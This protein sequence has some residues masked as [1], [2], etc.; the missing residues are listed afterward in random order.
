MAKLPEKAARKAGSLPEDEAS[1]EL[2]QEISRRISS[3]I[4]QGQRAQVVAQVVSVVSEERFS[5]PIAHP[6]HLREYEE[7]CPGAADR[8]IR[9][10]EQNL[11]HN[12]SMQKAWI[13]GEIAEAK[14][15]RQYGFGA[16]LALILAASYAAAHDHETIAGL[17]LGAGIL[18]V[19]G[20][21]IQGKQSQH[22][23][24]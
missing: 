18:G 19:I 3:L 17:F 10:A 4:P 16:L 21:L 14:A 6:K 12:Q 22:S 2:A 1:D 15:G 8:I 13:D 11:S 5:G 9:M 24:E 20:Q 7:V 23:D